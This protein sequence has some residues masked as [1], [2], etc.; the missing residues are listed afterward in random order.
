MWRSDRLYD[1]VIVVGHN[2]RPRVQ[3]GGSA[4]FIH[5][6]G[7]GKRGLIATE[8]CIAVRPRDL[9]LLLARIGV[10]TKVHIG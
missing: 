10:R 7:E 5:V 6:A 4:I 3:G 2:D 8:G 1:I 9:R